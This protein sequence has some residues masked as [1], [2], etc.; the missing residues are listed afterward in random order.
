ME[1]NFA[2]GTYNL[3]L[4]RMYIDTDASFAT[5]QNVPPEHLATYFHEYFHFL[6]DATTPFAFN[7]MWN[8]YARTA[9]LISHVQKAKTDIQLPLKNL[10]G[11]K[12]LARER[13]FMNAVLLDQLCMIKGKAAEGGITVNAMAVRTRTDFPD[14]PDVDGISFI[15]LALNDKNGDIGEYWFGGIAVI[16]TMTFLIQKKFFPTQ[17]VPDFPYMAAVRFA[18]YFYPEIGQNEEFVFALCDLAL[19]T[20]YPG[21]AFHELMQTMRQF[22]FLPKS[23]EQIYDFCIPVLERKFQIWERFDHY[24][25]KINLILNQLYGHQ[26][27][28]DNL[29]WHLYIIKKGYELRK[30]NP[31]LLLKLY[32]ERRP[33]D[34]TIYQFL[35]DLGAPEVINRN[36]ERW[37]NA[38]AALVHI[39]ATVHTLFISAISQIHNTLMDG[40]TKCVLYHHCKGSQPEMPIDEHCF[41]S[42]WEKA[43]K[44]PLCPFAASWAVFGLNQFAVKTFETDLDEMEFDIAEH[45]FNQLGFAKIRTGQWVEADL[46]GYMVRVDNPHV[47][48]MKRHIHI[49][50]KKHTSAKGEQVSWNEDGTR[51]DKQSFNENFSGMVQAKEIARMVLGIPSE[52]PLQFILF[53][54]EKVPKEIPITIN[55]LFF[56]QRD[57]DQPET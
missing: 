42:P 16:E 55:E 18:E 34:P 26:A 6:Q 36:N 11:I 2:K 53:K 12:E 9:D 30:S 17:D 43:K 49:A 5:L 32:R 31:L 54:E 7:V 33:F 38:P 29:E 41:T 4:F 52:T 57:E 13:E 47:E 51:H 56:I 23:A 37:F 48:G 28:K 39:Q 20:A 45:D 25:S 50:R 10:P 14:L 3:S 40:S 27:F 44:D 46:P 1:F 22:H 19:M 15:Q 35:D 24:K 21:W 8:V